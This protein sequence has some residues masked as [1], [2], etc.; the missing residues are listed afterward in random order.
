M[1]GRWAGRLIGNLVGQRLDELTFLDSRFPQ[2]GMEG[3]M[4]GMRL[5]RRLVLEKS[6]VPNLRKG[7]VKLRRRL[8]CRIVML[9]LI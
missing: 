5:N 7:E 6:V 2:W 9:V 4:M 1:K 3:R 8:G